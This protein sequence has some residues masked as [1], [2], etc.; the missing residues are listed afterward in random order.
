[1]VHGGSQTFTITPDLGYR[2]ADV[3]VDGSSEGPK[4]NHTFENVRSDHTIEATFVIDTCVTTASA[5]P[6]GSIIP[7]GNV[8]VTNGSCETFEIAPDEGYRVEDVE[9]NG[10]SVGAVTSHAICCDVTSAPTSSIHATFV[11]DIAPSVSITSP[12]EG[13]PLNQLFLAGGEASDQGSGVSKVELRIT[14]GTHYLTQNQWWTTTPTWMTVAGADIWLFNTNLV[15]WSSG[16]QYSV[17]ARATDEA[18]NTSSPFSVDFTYQEEPGARAYTTLSLD[19]SSQSIE[20]GGTIDVAG[21]LTRLPDTGEDLSDLT[22]TLTVTDPDDVTKTYTTN[23]YSEYGHYQIEGLSWFTQKGVYEIQASFDKTDTLYDAS[24]DVQTLLVGASAGY[25]I[26]VVGKMSDGEGFASHNKTAKRIYQRLKARGFADDN[27]KYFNYDTLHEAAIEPSKP[28]VQNAIEVWAAG[29]LIS[30]PAPLWI[31]MIDHGWNGV[32]YIDDDETMHEEETITPPELDSWMNALEENLGIV[33]PEALVEKRIFVIGACYSGSFISSLSK[34]G[35]VI[36]TSAA[37]DEESYKGPAEPPEPGEP[38]EGIRS[39]E[40]FLEKLF[41]ELKRGNSLWDSF[42][43]ATEKTERFTRKGG[44]LGHAANRYFD[45]AMQHP[46]LDDNADGQATNVLSEGYG[47]GILAKDIFLGISETFDVNP[48]N[49]SAELV[50]VTGTVYLNASPETTSYTMWAEANDNNS[51]STAWMEV[52]FPSLVLS[53]KG[54]TEQPD[55]PLDRELMTL[56]GSRWEETYD[57]FGQAGKYEVYYFVRDLETGE[58][59][60]A[61][62]SVVYKD[63]TDNGPPSSFNLVSPDNGSEQ[64][65]LLILDWEDTSDP[66]GVTYTI[67]ISVDAAFEDVVYR[68]E[69]I[70]ISIT[71]ID[72]AA[73]LQDLTTYFWKVEAVDSYGSVTESNQSWEF[74]TNNTNAFPGFIKGRVYNA[75]NYLPI[76]GANISTDAGVSAV[77]QEQGVFLM[78]APAGTFT[79]SCSGSGYEDVSIEDVSVSSGGSAGVNFEMVPGMEKGDVNNDGT[80][81]LADAVSALQLFA[82]IEPISTIYRQADVN[83][84]GKIGFQEVVYV[85]HN[86]CGLR[87]EP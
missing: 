71:L 64:K 38:A 67:L 11:D 34:E 81:D 44:D 76:M 7:V 39:G 47:D 10:M 54:G 65:T 78:L 83:E 8:E 2:V 87:I 20:N 84:D 70:P 68:Q 33:N 74:K 72:G 40:F 5:G 14:D 18:G 15:H 63:K 58:F 57:S 22:I 16:T 36:V 4:T 82:G 45:D 30:S 55:V 79:V 17:T 6:H 43:E 60:P 13:P 21:K 29:K 12:A 9:E 59:S 77:S 49:D 66:D 75:E 53:P 23:T 86:V 26:V 24:S 69:E 50:N 46:L 37:E 41:E 3:L 1:M 56:S 28:G 25:A 19:L 80:I 32:F 85:L 35:R 62:R 48:S 61:K 73:G 51:V 42:L 52:R 27:I 31:I